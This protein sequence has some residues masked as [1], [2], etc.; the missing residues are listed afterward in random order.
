MIEHRSRLAIAAAAMLGAM[1]LSDTMALAGWERFHADGANR[2]FVNVATAPA[3]RGSRSFPGLGTFAIGAGPVVA[4]DGTVYLGTEQGKLLARHA[5]GTPF[6]S[7]D[8]PK[9]QAIVSS[10][11]VGADGSV[12]VVGTKTV[13]DHRVDP[14]KTIFSSTL[15]KFTS[16]GGWIS[17]IPLPEHRGSGGATSAPPN[18]VSIGGQEIVLV[19]AVYESSGIDVRLIGASTAGAVVLDQFVTQE[20][21]SYTAG[22][23]AAGLADFE[24]LTPIIGQIACLLC[25]GNIFQN[26]DDYR[27]PAPPLPPMPGVAIF[28]F[29]GGGAPFVIINDQRHDLVGYTISSGPALKETFRV[30]DTKRRLIAPPMVLPDGHTLVGA[31]KDILFAGPNATPLPPV[32]L[33]AVHGAPTLTATGA[34]VAVGH[35]PAELL[36][37]RDGK[38]VSRASL[39]SDSLTSAAASRTHVFVSTTHAFIT[40]DADARKR[41]QTFDW[42]GGGTSPPAIGPRGHVYA[43]ASN[44]LFVF[45]PPAHVIPPIPGVTD[46]ARLHSRGQ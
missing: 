39:S 25:S 32:T 42:V 6:W 30:H 23:G 21:V 19:P 28:T 40:F 37:L 20:Q 12:Y 17:Q 41:V 36:V 27:P 34:V 14:P 1:L 24:C 33:G 26:C 31:L 9:G 3:G 10:P 16:S 29:A 46:P 22:A 35:L 38:A 45:P 11:V 2:G 8:L 18:I 13:R 15:H 7:R 44:I 43:I 4:P 5:D